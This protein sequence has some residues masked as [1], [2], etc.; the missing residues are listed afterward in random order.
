[1]APWLIDLV[2][3][4]PPRRVQRALVAALVISGVA[5][6]GDA[7]YYQSRADW[8]AWLVYNRARAELHDRP[9]FRKLTWEMRQ[10]IAGT[11]WSPVDTSL[12][13]QWVFF[14]DQIYDAERLRAVAGAVADQLPPVATAWDALKDRLERQGAMRRIGLPVLVCLAFGWRRGPYLVRGSAT[15]VLL[16]PLAL[17]LLHS[18]KLD[19]RWLR[20]MIDV[21]PIATMIWLAVPPPTPRH[22]ERWQ[23][24][25][26]VAL[27][28]LYAGEIWRP[29]RGHLTASEWNARIGTH[30]QDA[31]TR[32]T[33]YARDGARRG[34]P[35]L[36]VMLGR[37]IQPRWLNPLESIAILRDAPILRFGWLTHSP[38]YRLIL[39]RHGIRDVY[40]DVVQRKDLLLI[41]T[42]ATAK[43]FVA[44]LRERRQRLVEADVVPEFEDFQD[45]F[46]ATVYRLR[47][48]K[49]SPVGTGKHSLS[50]LI[51]EWRR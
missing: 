14:D 37:S 1:M 8:R 18:Y 7:L 38:H 31:L 13:S 15:G 2:R 30:L 45:L 33:S 32:L 47:D 49:T 23:R 51:H 17:W 25:V 20:P 26:G 3:P 28:L 24:A 44:F 29:M 21:I 34:E 46:G 41:S 11:G 40:A 43:L 10:R 5:T 22:G 35:V 36:F 9:Q 27:L 19:D 6:V 50:Q 4:K 39:E 42:P 12:F 16:L 48:S